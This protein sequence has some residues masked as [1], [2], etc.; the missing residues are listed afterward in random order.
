MAFGQLTQ[1]KVIS[2]LFLKQPM[3]KTLSYWH[4]RVINKTPYS[5]LIKLRLPYKRRPFR[6]RLFQNQ[7]GYKLNNHY[8]DLL[9]M[10]NSF[11]KKII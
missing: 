9:D 11:L 4:R 3:K 7:K 2:T 5:Q 10:S 1:W 6:L 8:T